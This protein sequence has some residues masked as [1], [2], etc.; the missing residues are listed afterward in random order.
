VIEPGPVTTPRSLFVLRN[1]K[2]TGFITRF[3][4]HHIPTPLL[5]GLGVDGQTIRYVGG[6]MGGETDTDG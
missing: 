5:K 2:D 6:Y 3:E 4:F 1:F